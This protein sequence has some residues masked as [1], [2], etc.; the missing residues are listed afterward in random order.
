M[1]H[2]RYLRNHIRGWLPKTP[3][4]PRV[5]DL[6]QAAC[7]EQKR[8]F[9]PALGGLLTIVG[10]F[11]VFFM[12]IF[13]FIPFISYCYFKITDFQFNN[14]PYVFQTSFVALVSVFCFIISFKAGT[15]AM[16]R[17]RYRLSIVG[18][19]L[20]LLA[21]SMTMVLIGLTEPSSLIPSLKFALPVAIL[22]ILGLVFLKISKKEFTPMKATFIGSNKVNFK[23]FIETVLRRWLPKE[24]SLPSPKKNRSG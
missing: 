10:S 7:L 16:Q 2:K 20:V 18:P 22:S 21:G 12:G 19:M 11:A 8:T 6:P 1:N 13:E 23:K 9:L 15:F 24:P 3:N 17:Q 5:A 4:N 14:N